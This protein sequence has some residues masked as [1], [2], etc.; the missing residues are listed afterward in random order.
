MK[1]L[2]VIFMFTLTPDGDIKE[3]Q[4]ATQSFATL[5]ECNY[6]GRHLRQIVGVDGPEYDEVKTLSYCV[7][8]EDYDPN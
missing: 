1:F 7:R 5:E 3:G 2:L 6:A 8:E 4:A